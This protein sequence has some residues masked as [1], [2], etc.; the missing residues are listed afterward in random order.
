MI[1]SGISFEKVDGKNMVVFPGDNTSESL[2]NAMMFFMGLVVI[3]C[4]MFPLGISTSSIYYELQNN[5]KR[6]K[7]NDSEK[8]KLV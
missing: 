1:N 2:N 7:L 4:S 6:K 3:T 5:R 8:E